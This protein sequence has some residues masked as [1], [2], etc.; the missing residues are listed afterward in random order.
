[1]KNYFNSPEFQRTLSRYEEAC[2]EGVSCYLDADDFVDLSDYYLDANQMDRALQAVEMGLTMHSDDDLL[3]CVRAGVLILQRRFAEAQAIVDE[4]GEDRNYDVIYLKAQLAFT[5]DHDVARANQEFNRWLVELEHDWRGAARG[6]NADE[7]DDGEPVSEEEAEEEIRNGMVHVIMTYSEFSP[8]NDRSQVVAWIHRYFNTYPEMG[9]YEADM[10]VGDVIRDEELVDEA[11][12]VYQR[13]LDYNPYF[14]EGWCMLSSVQQMKGNYAEALESVEFALAINPHDDQAILTKAHCCYGM[15][16]F[17]AAVP[18]YEDY[19][20]RVAHS[21]DVFLAFCYINLG[22]LELAHDRLDT[23]YA[24]EK[25]NR[26]D[27]ISDFYGRLG[28]IAEGYRMCKDYQKALLI[29]K[30]LCQRDAANYEWKMQQGSILLDI[31]QT[32]AAFEAFYDAIRLTTRYL[33]T[34][35]DVGVELANR[36]LSEMA[37]QV[38]ETV[39]RIA[40][41]YKAYESFPRYG[42]AHAYLAWAQV[43]EN[44]IEEGIATLKKACELSPEGVRTVFGEHL[45]PNLPPEEYFSYLTSST[46]P[47]SAQAEDSLPD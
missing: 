4:V 3:L 27:K 24:Y 23:A 40:S 31:G 25:D 38:L 19:H 16:N 44:K 41:R 39:L 17:E 32:E 5:V 33:D 6:E 43:R 2:R 1:M 20:N 9:R 8:A 42:L 35:F 18:L 26:F 15:G 11:L 30:D 13:Y 29:N 28:E 7:E 36:N 14:Q 22:Q 10:L 12:T 47:P 46:S 37:L 34:L 45:P 21:E